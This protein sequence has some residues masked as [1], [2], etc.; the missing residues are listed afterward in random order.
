MPHHLPTAVTPD[1]AT[2]VYAEHRELLFSIVYNLLGSVSD[3][4]DVL[5]DTWLA[6]AARGMDDVEKPRAYLVRIAV[7]TAL[8]RQA[9]V[10]R[11]R[12]SY[13][14]PWLPE[15]LVGAAGTG[16]G[17]GDDAADDVARGEAVSLA[18]L[19]VL[20][21]LTP[22]SR[23]VFILHEVF[24]YPHTEIAEILGRSPASVRQV[25]HRAKLHVRARRRRRSIDRR[26]QRAATE[27]F[28]AAALG[29]DLAEL[30]KILA[31]DVTMWT[32][33]GGV[34]RAALRPIEGRDKVARLITSGVYQRPDELDIRYRTVNGDPSAVLFDGDAPFAVMVLDMAADGERVEGIYAV[35][36]PDKLGHLVDAS[37]DEEE[38]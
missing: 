18:M 26:T 34:R 19:V 15:P 33:G 30:M 14:G 16:T 25:A 3:T 1:E 24:G 23:A 11:R 9:A 17:P 31:P 21:T 28:L 7:N 13:P 12:E 32:D 4:E 5:Q 20:E 2:E 36:N 38:G 27:R 6:W 35:S 8:A 10:A 29:G 37:E 22:L